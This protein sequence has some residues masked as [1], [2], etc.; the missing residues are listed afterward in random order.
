[1]GRARVAMDA[2]TATRVTIPIVIP[3]DLRGDRW[4]EVARDGAPDAEPADDVRWHLVRVAETPGVVAVVTVPDFDARD[5]VRTLDDVLEVPVRSYVELSRGRWQR[6]D[7]FEPVTREVVQAAARNADLLVVRGDTTG[8]AQLGR[9]R[10][11]WPPATELGDWYVQLGGLSPVAGALR[12]VSPE[13]LPSLTGVAGAPDGVEWAAL[14]ALRDRRG[15]ARPVIVGRESGGRTIVMLGDGFHRWAIGGGLAASAWRTLVGES[16]AWLLAA[17]PV[18]AAAVRTEAPVVQRGQPLTWRVAPGRDTIPVVVELEGP[19][20]ARRDTLRVEADGRA[21]LELPVGRY[22]W[23]AE[24]ASGLVG[25]EPFAEELVPA[26]VTLEAAEATV[27][28]TPARRSLR[29]VWPL[30][31]LAMAGLMID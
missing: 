21:Q 27:V 4:F 14:E 29:D 1:L 11:L 22:A 12:G 25:V 31:A 28:P 8:W 7:T 15:G 2:G 10:L 16:A 5:L 19:D 23:R 26:S 18:T 20:G 24:G 9:A 3:A 30:F 6:S 17:A 13:T